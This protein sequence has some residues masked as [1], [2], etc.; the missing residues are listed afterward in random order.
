MKNVEYEIKGKIMT[1]KIDI[2]Q[3]FGPS[4]SGKSE[5]IASTEGNKRIKADDQDI[6][7]GL[8]CYKKIEKPK[9]EKAE[10]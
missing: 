8:N 4:K 6:W 3:S 10:E 9:E 1:I 7:L 2:T 5:M